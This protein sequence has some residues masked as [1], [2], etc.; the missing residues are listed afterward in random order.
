MKNCADR[1]DPHVRRLD[2]NQRRRALGRPDP[3]TPEG[4]KAIG[5]R[6]SHGNQYSLL[7]LRSSETGARTRPGGASGTPPAGEG[8]PCALWRIVEL[9]KRC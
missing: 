1:L 8:Y 5:L 7:V 6:R 4:G 2:V 9:L 3:P